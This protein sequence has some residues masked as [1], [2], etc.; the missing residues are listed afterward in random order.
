M[1]LEVDRGA[2]LESTMR[3]LATSLARRLN[4]CFERTGKVFAGRYHAHALR[5]PSEARNALAYVLLNARKHAFEDGKVLPADWI[6]PRSTGVTFDGWDREI[7]RSFATY[8]FGTST[9]ST[10]L[11][12]Q[13]WRRHG[14]IGLDEIPGAEPRRARRKSAEIKIGASGRSGR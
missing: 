12:R 3:S 2:C 9:A 6:D 5:T 13:G 7:D 11:L 8:D 1:M 10:W 14:P 4:A